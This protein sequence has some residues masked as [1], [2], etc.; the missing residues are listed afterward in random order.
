DRAISALPTRADIFA[1]LRRASVIER[2]CARNQG[3]I[4]QRRRTARNIVVWRALGESNPCLSLERAG[5]QPPGTT[6]T[7]PSSPVAYHSPP[8]SR[9]LP[10]CR[11]SFFRF[12][13][14]N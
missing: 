6:W 1:G 12:G 2:H 9:L 5:R 14:A 13:A 7:T 11:H 3:C 4:G 8:T 10:D